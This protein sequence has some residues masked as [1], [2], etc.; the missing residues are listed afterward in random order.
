MMGQT[1]EESTAHS[2]PSCL[3]GQMGL[4]AEEDRAACAETAERQVVPVR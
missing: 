4:V 1:F 2:L 3:V